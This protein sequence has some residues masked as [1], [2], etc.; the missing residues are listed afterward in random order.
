MS[1]QT[2]VISVIG[3]MSVNLDTSVNL[4]EVVEKFSLAKLGKLIFV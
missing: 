1:M 2:W 3:V 4:N